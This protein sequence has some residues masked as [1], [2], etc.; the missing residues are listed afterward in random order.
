MLINSKS[1]LCRRSSSV[2][3][4]PDET[5]AIE[6]G[7]Y[8]D[9]EESSITSL[10]THSSLTSALS[11]FVPKQEKHSSLS[12]HHRLLEEDILGIGSLPPLKFTKES[13]TDFK[14]RVRKLANNFDLN[15]NAIAD[16]QARKTRMGALNWEV[17]FFYPSL[18][19]S[20]GLTF[21]FS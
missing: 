21:Y 2:S 8:R 6:L 9:R 4:P 3:G 11:S 7:Y 16:A 1:L 20:H 17:R 19:L 15:L 13:T 5:Q 18:F 14:I 12:H 10:R